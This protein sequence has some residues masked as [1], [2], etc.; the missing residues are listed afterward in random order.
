[1]SFTSVDRSGLR[2]FDV[3]E[4]GILQTR[5]LSDERSTYWPELLF[6]QPRMPGC[7]S[8]RSTTA[9]A[10]TPA[11]TCSRPP[12]TNSYDSL[13]PVVE[14]NGS[15][16]E[17]NV[18]SNIPGVTQA[19]AGPDLHCCSWTRAARSGTRRTMPAW[20][21]RHVVRGSR[22]IALAAAER[23]LS[24]RRASQLRPASNHCPTDRAA[25]SRLPRSLLS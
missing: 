13:R 19:R 23:L 7:T 17:I 24:K 25:T 5:L 14:N 2:R 18:N 16:K 4:V 3:M 8:R 20:S 21:S 6:A 15:S 22:G 9:S 10:G 11:S 1:M 12:P